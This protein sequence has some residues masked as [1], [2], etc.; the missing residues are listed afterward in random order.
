MATPVEQ[1]TAEVKSMCYVIGEAACGCLFFL[2]IVLIE[3]QQCF[4]I[5]NYVFIHIYIVIVKLLL[6]FLEVNN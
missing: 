4:G 1:F 2:Y 5:V 6:T 3:Y